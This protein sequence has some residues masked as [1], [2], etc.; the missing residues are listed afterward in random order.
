MYVVSDRPAGQQ[1][2]TT[3]CIGLLF[4]QNYSWGDG[5]GQNPVPQPLTFR[6]ILASTS[7]T[8]QQEAVPEVCWKKRRVFPK[9]VLVS[10]EQLAFSPP[11]PLLFSS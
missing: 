11:N 7:I 9:R 6:R 1:A 3:V 4:V 10:G 2:A 8:W 5:I